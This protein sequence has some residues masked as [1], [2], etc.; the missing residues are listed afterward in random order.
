MSQATRYGTAIQLDVYKESDPYGPQKFRENERKPDESNR[1]F[2]KTITLCPSSMIMKERWQTAYPLN[3]W[4]TLIFSWA[5]PTTNSFLVLPYVHVL[6][7]IGDCLLKLQQIRV[8]YKPQK[9]TNSLFHDRS[10][11]T[12]LIVNLPEW[13]IKSVSGSAISYTT[14]KRKIAEDSDLQAQRKTVLMLDPR[15]KVASDVYKCYHQIDFDYVK[16][17]GRE[18]HYHQRLFLET[19]MSVKDPNAGND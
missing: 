15:L 3:H 14:T 4:E 16:V 10:S 17:V 7:E 12:K 2:E 8:S 19:W 9:N 6:F 18:P 5:E 1:C 11:R 13:F